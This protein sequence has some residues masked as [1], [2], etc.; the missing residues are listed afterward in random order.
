MYILQKQ[1][2]NQTEALKYTI[3]QYMQT[4]DVLEY[5]IV[6]KVVYLLC[7]VIPTTWMKSFK[8]IAVLHFSHVKDVWS[9]VE[10]DESMNPSQFL[11]CPLKYLDLTDSLTDQARTWKESCLSYR[12]NKLN[13]KKILQTKISLLEEKMR[14]KKNCILVSIKHGELTL[15]NFH[16]NSKSQ[17]IARN[18]DGAVFRYKLLDFTVDEIKNI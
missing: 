6:G 8:Y 3:D 4:V 17:I 13:S 10:Y 1:F 2:E 14:N 18:V 15:M 9:C 11:D 7:E 12:K 5:T 16:S